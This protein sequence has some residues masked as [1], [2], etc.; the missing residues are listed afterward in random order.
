MKQVTG[1]LA[2]LVVGVVASPAAA[3]PWY[4]GEFSAEVTMSS[5]DNP[6]NQATGRVFVG[7]GRLRA[8]GSYRGQSKVVLID[9]TNHKAWTLL[10]TSKQYYE[11]V[12]DAPVPPQ[13]D[14]EPMPSD[15]DSPCNTS[16]GQVKCSKTGTENVGGVAA[17]KWVIVRAFQ[18]RTM[19]VNLWVDAQRRIVLRQEA[20]DGPI[21]ERLFKGMED[22]NGRQTEKWEFVRSFRGQ[23]MS[24]TQ[25]ID[26]RLRI[27]VRGMS[28]D[29]KYLLE[30]RNIQEGPQA[31]AL[32]V[33]PGDFQ[34]VAAPKMPDPRM[35][36]EGGPPPQGGPQGGTEPPGGNRYPPR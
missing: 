18:N 34:Q 12:A 9:D 28:S 1:A 7:K 35:G 27:P 11:G 32:F 6:S 19:Q 33:L 20:Q 31:D 29:Q 26:A 23:S 5:K 13:P 8:E 2:L 25:W 36:G 24:S 17:E 3:A 30:V 16:A 22:V 15:A 4:G 14:V 21:M 10:P